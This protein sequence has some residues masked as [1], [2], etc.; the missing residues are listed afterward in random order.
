MYDCFDDNATRSELE[1]RVSHIQPVELLISDSVDLK[2]EKLVMNISSLRYI[3][4][5]FS[6][7]G[8]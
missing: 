4:I 7:G 1:T 3:Y 5:L 6:F 8:P 2:T